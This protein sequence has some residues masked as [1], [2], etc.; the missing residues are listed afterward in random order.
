[1]FG[2]DGIF[3]LPQLGGRTLAQL[4][5][6]EKNRISHRARAWRQA[7]PLLVELLVAG[8]WRR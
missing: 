4:S 1:G 8:G 5:L 7:E 3:E 6:E 2:Y